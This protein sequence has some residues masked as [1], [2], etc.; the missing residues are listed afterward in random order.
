MNK[1]K[2]LNFPDEDALWEFIR[3]RLKGT[4]WRLEA[5]TPDGLTDALGLWNQSTWW[6]E[7]K[8]GKPGR[9]AF[10]PSQRQ[11]GIDCMRQGVPI[12]S[13]FGYRGE[14]LFFLDFNFDVPVVPP[15]Y[16]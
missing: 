5:I 8:V 6:C 14:A 1:S 13:C 3:P 10:R 12:Y 11:F 16:R 9:S 15:F 4:W 7:L 2:K